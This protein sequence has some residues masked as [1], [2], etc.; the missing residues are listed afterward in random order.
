MARRQL[1]GFTQGLSKSKLLAQL[2]GEWPWSE[3][4][5]QASAPW[6]QDRKMLFAVHCPAQLRLRIGSLQS[7]DVAEKGWLF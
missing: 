6:A 3:L 7:R 1:V 5:K 2:Q 4:G